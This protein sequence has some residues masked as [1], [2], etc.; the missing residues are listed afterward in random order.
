MIVPRSHL[1]LKNNN[2]SFVFLFE[3]Y[4]HCV[5]LFWTVMIIYGHLPFLCY[6]FG[7]ESDIYILRTNLSSKFPS[8][9]KNLPSFSKI[10]SASFTQKKKNIVLN[11]WK[12]LV[13]FLSSMSTKNY[14]NHYLHEIN[15]N[16][17]KVR[18][19]LHQKRKSKSYPY[20]RKMHLISHHKNCSYTIIFFILLTNIPFIPLS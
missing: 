17:H 1:I 14:L 13:K 18:S 7:G 15:P 19:N 11:L 4:H 20:H 16:L 12:S 6:L 3:S 2:L 10:Y 9:S 5:S 8:F